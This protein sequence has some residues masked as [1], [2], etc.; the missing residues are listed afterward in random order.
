MKKKTKQAKKPTKKP[1]K[2]SKKERKENGFPKPPQTTQIR[3]A[4]QRYGFTQTQAG[5]LI[6]YRLNGWQR[7]EYGVRAMH[8]ALWEFWQLRAAEEHA[9]RSGDPPPPA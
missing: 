6:Y 5:A 1:T 8:P 9:K 4:R 2:K 7:L 3:T